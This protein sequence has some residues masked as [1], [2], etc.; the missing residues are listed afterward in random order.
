MR[1]AQNNGATIW[2]QEQQTVVRLAIVTCIVQG[3]QLSKVAT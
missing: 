3:L 2:P 1:V